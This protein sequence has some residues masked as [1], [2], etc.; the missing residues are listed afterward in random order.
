VAYFRLWRRV[1]LFPG[2]TVNLSK[3]GASVSAGVRGAHVTVGRR[4]I[5]KT[6]GIPGTGMFITDQK[7]WKTANPPPYPTQWKGHDAT[8][9]D[10]PDIMEYFKEQGYPESVWEKFRV[11]DGSLPPA[12]PPPASLGATILGIF[13]CLAM[14]ILLAQMISSSRETTANVSPS[15]QT[16]HY[17]SE[18]DIENAKND[19]RTYRIMQEGGKTVETTTLKACLAGAAVK[20][21]QGLPAKI[22]SNNLVGACLPDLTSVDKIIRNA[23]TSGRESFGFIYANYIAPAMAPA[24]PR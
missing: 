24:H 8:E 15:V 9:A 16:S 5:R 21:A 1:R 13:V 17:M 3:R 14:I 6:V 12:P 18:A 23:G 20:Q 2:L 11:S 22:L 7:S 4:G 19:A 10:L